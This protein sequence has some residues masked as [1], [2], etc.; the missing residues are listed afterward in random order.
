[1]FDAKGYLEK[2]KLPGP[3]WSALASAVNRAMESLETKK[4]R[5][6]TIRANADSL[7]AL[8]LAISLNDGSTDLGGTYQGATLLPD[9]ALTDGDFVVMG[10]SEVNR[11]LIYCDPWEPYWLDQV[12]EKSRAARKRENRMDDESAEESEPAP[13]EDDI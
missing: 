13:L 12:K 7:E 1:M 4:D 10:V 6:K 2:I 5:A 8:E 3:N 9:G 11:I